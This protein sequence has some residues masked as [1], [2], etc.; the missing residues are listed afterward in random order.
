MYKDITKKKH[1]T[2]NR[3]VFF[4]KQ[5]ILNFAV[6]NVCCSARTLYQHG[7]IVWKYRWYNPNKFNK[8]SLQ[9]RLTYNNLIHYLLLILKTIFHYHC[10][11]FFIE[12]EEGLFPRLKEQIL[13]YQFHFLIETKNENKVCKYCNFLSGLLNNFILSGSESDSVKRYMYCQK[14]KKQGFFN[15]R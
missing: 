12:S 6:S 5:F 7:P 3:I 14:G 15:E 13:N 8:K 11:P 1:F 2:R 10:L 4:I 9:R